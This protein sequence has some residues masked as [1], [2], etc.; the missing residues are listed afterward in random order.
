MFTFPLAP[1]ALFIERSQQFSSWGIPRHV[2][3]RVQANI[4]D[5]WHE[6]PGGW[7]YE[8]AIPAI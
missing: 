8:N 3:H 7:P 6:G 4:K 1:N 2:I 5:N